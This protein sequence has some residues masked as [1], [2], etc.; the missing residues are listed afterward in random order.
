M[1][2][3]LLAMLIV[4]TALPAA[5]RGPGYVGIWA[6]DAKSCKS[7]RPPDERLKISIQMVRGYESACKITATSPGKW[8]GIWYV[9]SSCTGEG[10][11]WMRRDIYA[12]RGGGKRLVIVDQEGFAVNYVRCG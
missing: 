6:V 7:K 2:T 1:R 10:Q 11:T 12:T 4:F 9:T 3:V 5:A 8:P